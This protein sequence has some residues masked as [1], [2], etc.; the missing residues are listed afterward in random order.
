MYADQD[1]W[2][3]DCVMANAM[4]SSWIL[5]IDTDEFPT[6]NWSAESPLDQFKNFM[7]QIPVD[8]GA[9]IF[10]RLEMA[11]DFERGA[12]PQDELTQASYE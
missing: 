6:V 7:R 10:D 1:V 9:V 12:P 4:S 11:R 3:Q 2:Y 8:K 5:I